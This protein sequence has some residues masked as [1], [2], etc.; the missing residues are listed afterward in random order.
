MGVQTSST[1]NQYVWTDDAISR[2]WHHLAG[3]FGRKVYE[4]YGPEM[5]KEWRMHVTTLSLD[6]AAAVLQQYGRSGDAFAP[7]L[8]QLMASARA[9][10]LSAEPEAL[11]LPKP[12]DPEL[13]QKAFAT[14]KSIKRKKIRS[15]F[16]PGESLVDYQQALA[17]SGMS[18]VDFEAQRL[19]ESRW[20]PDDE[21][22]YRHASIT[23]GMGGH[24]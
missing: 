20:T 16:K 7:T 9:I 2:F 24:S 22:A 18:R 15:V 5:P 6:R 8:S 4:E 14:T 17:A 3:I 13:A 21:V 19:V 23:C 10:R 12:S 1:Q 11:A